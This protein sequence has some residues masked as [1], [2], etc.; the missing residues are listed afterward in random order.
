MPIT[1]RVDTSNVYNVIIGEGLLEQ[2]GALIKDA[3]PGASRVMIISDSNVWPIYGRRLEESLSS[4]GY[5]VYHH[6]LEAGEASKSMK[7]YAGIL[8]KLA[9]NNFGRRD[10]IAALGG[11][12]IG[13]ISGFAGATYMRGIR[14]IQIPTTLLSAVDSSVGGKT[15]IDLPEGKNLAG[16]FH[17]PS[18]VICDTETL[19]TLSFDTF[20]DGCA[21]VIKYALIGDSDMF[22]NLLEVMVED[23][24]EEIIAACVSMKR[25]I[26]SEDEFDTGRRAI[27]NMGHTFGHAIEKLSGLEVTHGQA[28]A[29]GMNIAARAA[30]RKGFC[31]ELVPYLVE[32]IS[33]QY[34]LPTE[35]GFSAREIAEAAASDKKADADSI[36]IIVPTGVGSC[37][38]EKIRMEELEGWCE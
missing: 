5:R 27:L 26:V 13:D 22:D 14:Y 18:L 21:E 7:S 37:R 29:I 4:E 8:S 30:C 19:E 28:V 33:R 25:D 16:A 11:G 10:I 17:Q 32:R 35:T 34:S 1:V 38:I 15:A 12:M 20:R 36:S 2:S 24:V 6:V 23:H 3:A 31:D 9:E